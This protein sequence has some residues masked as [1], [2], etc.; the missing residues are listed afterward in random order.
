[1]KRLMI[2][3][4]CI[5]AG[6]MSGCRGAALLPAMSPVVPT[7]TLTASPAIV[8]PGSSATLSWTTAY[9]ST[10]TIS[11]GIG[12]VAASGSMAITPSS[13]TEYTLT[14]TSVNGTATSA[15]TVTVHANPP[16]AKLT[17][18]PTTI[19]V[20][21]SATLTWSTTNATSVSIDNGIGTVAASGS[22]TVSPTTTTTYTLTATGDGGTVT[23]TATVTVQELMPTAKLTA[24]PSTITAGQT[25]TLT[26][27]TTNATTVSIDQGIG[28]VS[29]SGTTVVSPTN[30][31]QYTLTAT[32]S[33][34][35]ATASTTVTVQTIGVTNSPITH[36]IILMMQNHSLDNLFGTYPGANGLNATLPS[37]HQVD[38][39]GNTVSPTPITSLT[40]PDLT[41]DQPHYAGSWD[42]GKMDKFAYT[43]GDLAMQYY[44]ASLS[45]MTTDNKPYGI[46]NLWSYAQQYALAD[47]F[48]MS[49]MNSEPAQ[50]LYMVAATVHSNHNASA[51]PFYDPCSAVEQQAQ[52]GGTISVPMTETNV[53]DQ[54]TA[55][56]LTWTFYQTNYTNSQNGT[57]TDYVPQQN[58]FQ[59]FTSTEN[60][61]HIQNFTMSGFQT[62]LNNGTLPSVVWITPDGAHDMH[63]GGGNILDGI[64]WLSQLVQAVKS[65]GEWQSTA[66]VVLF[67]ESGGW[68]DHVPP[69]QL[70][71]T[72]AGTLPGGQ[73]FG[74]RVPVII[75]SPYAKTNYISHQ[76][77]DF[78]S[79][80]RFIQWNWNLGEIPATAQ[81]AREQ[82]SGDLCDLLTSPC[83]APSP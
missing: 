45:G 20:G 10:V 56:Q 62:V 68:Y 77:M 40:T 31:T 83:G 61:S 42:N 5:C 17:A 38:A 70:T 49:A 7:A 41:H 11:N 29:S 76:Q 79:I 65:S 52:G 82:Q 55:K 36:L 47:N 16:T 8:A 1:M 2:V 58:V 63:P 50:E 74:M 35:T 53:G 80:L 18:A 75:I 69:P 26:W 81:Q 39:A 22:T 67:D 48:Y 54:L 6:L 13:T 60:S 24:S 25:S 37:Y 3:S 59:Y 14:A 71:D 43:E 64:E 72:D 4:V 44:N 28:A 9:A 46:T 78:V 27:T 32:G 66:I 21:N 34:G 15:A 30:T 73:G 51:L 23:A 57:C 19:F 33:G 12:V